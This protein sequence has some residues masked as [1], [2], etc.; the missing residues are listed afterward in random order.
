M[1]EIFIFP[2]KMAINW[3]VDP[4]FSDSHRCQDNLRS[5][6]R[7]HGLRSWPQGFA[8]PA[9]GRIHDLKHGKLRNP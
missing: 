9:A 3:A 2:M 1:V 8:V 4:A 7:D 6:V 5:Y